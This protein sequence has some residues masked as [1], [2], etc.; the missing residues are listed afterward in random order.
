MRR[1]SISLAFVAAACGSSPHNA[2]PPPVIPVDTGRHREDVEAQVKPY[3]DA[4]VV[5][6]LVVALYDAGKTEVYGFGRGP[7]NAPPDGTTLFELGPLTKIY[8]AILLADAVQRREVELDTPV[9]ELL[10]PGVTVPIRDKVVITLKHLALHSSGLP[11]LPPSL[12]ANP[13]ANPFARYSE[14]ALYADLIRSD[15]VATPGTKI[16]YSTFGAGLLGFALGRKLGGGY[17]KQLGDRVLRP[18]ELKDTFLAV[19]PAAAPRRAAGTTDDLAP[20]T[21]WT[22]D[23][24]AGAGG[25]VSTANDQLVLLEAELDAA[26]GGSRALRHAMKLTQEPQLDRAGDNMG[27]GWMIDSAGRYWHNGGTG[28]FHAFMSFDPKSKRGVVLLASTAT[29]M[30]DRLSEA[31]YKILDGTA[32]PV[33]KFAG[34]AELAAFA[35]TYDLSGTKLKVTVEGKRLYLEG[36][37]EPRHRLTPISDH[38]FWIE[39][40]QSSAAFERTGDKV[41]RVVFGVGDHTLAAPRV[42]AP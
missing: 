24:L 10:P 41:G 8:T 25:L 21:A 40:L 5:S 28:G 7:N 42:E 30:A 32:P 12:M 37:G 9:A 13:D 35:G 3:I 14:D 11:P 19:P 20:A 6:G 27:L 23:A 18:L 36:P 16:A 1:S 2:K 39:A 4:E 22:F 15:L 17:A 33:A 26:A 29:A 34:A 31:L 38:E